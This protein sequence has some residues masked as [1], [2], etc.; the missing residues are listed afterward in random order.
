M[1]APEISFIASSVATAGVMCNFSILKWTASTTTIALSTTIPIA[2]TNANKVIRFKEN[3]KNCINK[4]VPISDTGTVNAGIRVDL[5]SCKKIN[6]T[7]ET[8]KKAS[9]NVFNT[10]LMEAFKK[11]DTS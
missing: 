5:Q 9:N 1:I 2:N 4:K 10:T 6:T 7:K 11:L 3:P 8:N